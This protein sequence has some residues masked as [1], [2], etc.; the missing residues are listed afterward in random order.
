LFLLPALLIYVLLEIIPV[1]Q[2]FYFSFFDWPGIQGVPLKFVGLRN[3]I[4]LLKSKLF[5]TSI[6]NILWFVGLSL[7]TQLPIGFLFAILLSNFCKGYRFFK[8]SYFIPLVLPI[9][10]TSLLWRFILFPNEMG[11]LNHI[12][13]SLGLGNLATGWLINKSTAMTAVIL[14]TAWG[15]TAYYLTIGF[16]AVTGIP[17][18]VLESAE[19]DGA[20]GVKKVFYITIPMVWEAIKISIIMIITGVLKIFDI[21]FVMTE[22]GPNG[23]T[24][25]PATLMYYEAFKYNHYGLGSAISTII[26]LMSIIITVISLK[27]MTG[28]KYEY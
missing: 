26:F 1:I 8:A 23:L 17:D 6:K 22:G 5:L 4:D 7:L 21:V 27:L 28:E 25:V 2:S 13:I 12:L 20:S 9:T 15:G 16:A 14:V 19:I 18:D 3:F 10:A 24:H 11:V